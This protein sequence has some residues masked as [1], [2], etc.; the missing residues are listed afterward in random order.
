MV[1][2]MK[3][4]DRL[5]IL[6]MLSTKTI[7]GVTK[8]IPDFD[9][10]L[11]LLARD[12][13]FV[14][15]EMFNMQFIRMIFFCYFVYFSFGFCFIQ[16]VVFFHFSAN[17][18]YLMLWTTT[19]V[20]A[21]GDWF[22]FFFLKVYFAGG[23]VVVVC[24]FCSEMFRTYIYTILWPRFAQVN[25]AFL[26]MNLKNRVHKWWIFWLHFYIGKERWAK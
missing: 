9:C 2:R 13:Q 19:I 10:V 14:C 7:S 22:H 8:C 25:N 3:S 12:T 6:E 1:A 26:T 21:C 17:I 4:L 15:I 23:G 16:F 18:L 5:E 20:R 11:K 24:K